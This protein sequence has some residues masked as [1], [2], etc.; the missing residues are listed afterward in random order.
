HLILVSN[1]VGMGLVPPYPLGRAFRDLLGWANRYMAEKADIVLF[2][3]AGIPLVLKGGDAYE[4]IMS[5]AGPC[6]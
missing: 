3:L 6:T 5:K 1:E 4:G 2:I